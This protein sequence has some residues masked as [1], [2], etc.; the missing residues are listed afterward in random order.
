L[1][2]AQIKVE[3]Q[4]AHFPPR[5]QPIGSTKTPQSITQWVSTYFRHFLSVS[6]KHSGFIKI[7]EKSE[8]EKKNL[9]TIRDSSP[10]LALSNN[11]TFGQTQTG[12]TVP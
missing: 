11:S 5:F 4:R 3:T 7:N 2:N 6:S 1:G 9:K 8:T 10:I 12:A